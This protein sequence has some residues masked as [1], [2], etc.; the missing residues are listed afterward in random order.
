MAIHTSLLGFQANYILIL[1]MLIN[2]LVDRFNK[3]IMDNKQILKLITE[4]DNYKM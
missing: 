4:H 3:V 2:M 1:N